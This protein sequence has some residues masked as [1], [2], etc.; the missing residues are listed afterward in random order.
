MNVNQFASRCHTNSRANVLQHASFTFRFA[1]FADFAAVANDAVREVDPF[2]LWQL[3]IEIMLDLHSV[4]L[5][6]H[7]ESTTDACDVCIN[8]DSRRDTKCIA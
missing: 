8:H 4:F 5:F 3:L 7:A 1:R 2:F 6:G